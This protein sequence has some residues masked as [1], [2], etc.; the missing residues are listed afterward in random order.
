MAITVTPI[1][2]GRYKDLDGRFPSRASLSVGGLTNSATAPTANIIPHGLPHQPQFVGLR[3]GAA[4]LWGET[5]PP[6]ATNI[7]ITVGI[8]G[9][10]TGTLDVEY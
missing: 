4:G 3:P 1:N 2:Y 8:G 10:I 9:A 6:D 7:Y 5:S